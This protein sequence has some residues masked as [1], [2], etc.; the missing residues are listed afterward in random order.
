M[1]RRD[2]AMVV[3]GDLAVFLAFVMLG[4]AEHGIA[5]GTPLIRT[6]LPFT[7][8]WF[9]ASPWLGAYKVSTIYPLRTTIWKI[10]SIWLLCGLLALLGRTFFMNQPWLLSFVLVSLAVQGVLLISWRTTFMMVAQ[11]LFRP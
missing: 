6:A 10:P 7:I 8:V 5:D 3:L 1:R 2:I 4:K 9:V 11:R